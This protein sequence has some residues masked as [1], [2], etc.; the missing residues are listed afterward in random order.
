MLTFLFF[1]WF[2]LMGTGPCKGYAEPLKARCKADPMNQSNKTEKSHGPVQ[3]IGEYRKI[4][5]VCLFSLF[6]DIK[7]NT[8]PI[9]TNT[10]NVCQTCSFWPK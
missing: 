4:A 9:Q 10:M 8:K 6:L 1:D 5:I 2:L 7:T 3:H